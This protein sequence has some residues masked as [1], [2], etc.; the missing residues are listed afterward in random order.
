MMRATQMDE[1]SVLADDYTVGQNELTLRYPK[2]NL[3]AGMVVCAGLNTFIVL[4]VGAG[5]QTLT[6]YPSG[7]GG[8]EVAVPHGTL[9]RI[10]PAV[11]T[12]SLLREWNSALT[13]MSAPPNGITGFGMFESV[14]DYVANVYP[15]PDTDP[16][17]TRQ[18]IRVLA[19]Q[20]HA[21]GQDVWRNLNGVEYQH[22]VRTIKVVG[23]VPDAT[24]LRFTL[25]FPF[26]QATDLTTDTTVLGLNQYNE[27]IPGLGAAAMLALGD[28]GRRNQ[29]VRQGD[30]RRAGEVQAGANIGMARA[31]QAAF[32]QR[33]I[34]ETARQG[35]LY[36]YRMQDV[37]NG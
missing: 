10:R 5:G 32:K 31:F 21:I 3:Q 9:V 34:E 24:Q 36:P 27:D 7:D 2:P 13:S 17:T 12:W 23:R 29:P 35:T 25:S 30:P 22:T 16:W 8:P 33:I 1:V 28:E 19:A 18:P 6:V 15:L 20:Y 14:P 11:T 26:D 37:V 4:A